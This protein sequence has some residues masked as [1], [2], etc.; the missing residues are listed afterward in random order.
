[1]NLTQISGSVAYFSSV[2]VLLVF[3]L[4]SIIGTFKQ[5]GIFRAISMFV[6]L[7]VFII[8][9]E[10]LAIKTSLPYGKFSYSDVLSFRLFGTAPWIVALS[11]PPIIIGAF[12]LAR[13]MS[14]GVLVPIFT[15]L[16]T[17]LTYV[18][19]APAMAKLT[20]WQW[21]A[22]GRF[23]G[24]HLRSFIGWFI[25]AFI[26]ALI[27]KALWGEGETKRLVAYSWFAVILFWAGVNLGVGLLIPFLIGLAFSVFLLVLFIRERRQDK[28]AE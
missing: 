25:C 10:T 19:L 11:Y 8:G 4:P 28:K 24:V 13:K 9:F 20:L 14:I 5:S 1:M 2:I 27:V 7:G 16:F 17:T 3:A 26:S 23:F 21:E 15:A 6:I 12:W 18:V 22:P